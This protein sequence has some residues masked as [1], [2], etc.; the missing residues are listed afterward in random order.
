MPYHTAK[1]AIV[2]FMHGGRFE[3][4]FQQ[5]KYTIRKLSEFFS[6]SLEMAKNR[7]AELGYEEVKGVL[8]YINR[9]YIPSYLTDKG[10]EY[11][12]LNCQPKISPNLAYVSVRKDAE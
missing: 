10:M 2:N 6:V 7:M 4:T 11:N 12:K 1:T 3:N 9:R 5:T 8:N